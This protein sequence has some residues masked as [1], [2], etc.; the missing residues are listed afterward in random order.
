VSPRASTPF[1]LERLRREGPA[2]FE[3]LWCEQ[4]PLGPLAGRYRG[5]VLSRIDHAT[6][7][8]PLWRWSQRAG[9]EGLPF[10]VDF[11]RRCWCFVTPSLALGRFEARPGRSRWRDTEAYAL[12]YDTSRLP[13]LI[14]LVLY[15]EVKPLDER[16]VLGLGGI[17]AD[18]GRG[19]HF[20]FV[21]E[22]A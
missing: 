20:R 12:C 21:L 22:R 17:A 4:R 6:S 14:R 7:R 10:W 13:P 19:D 16:L 5:H 3:A 1:T 11:D 2:G 8:R 9:F 15:D 18:R